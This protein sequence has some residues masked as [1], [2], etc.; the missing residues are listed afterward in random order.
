MKTK[1]KWYSIEN[2]SNDVTDIYI[3]DTIGQDYW[4]DGISGETFI[5]DLVKVTTD[6]INFWVNCPGGNVFEAN[7][8]FNAIK[9]HPAKNKIM[10]I[11][12]MAASAASYI[13]MACDERIIYDGGVIM[14]HLPS[15][16]SYG[17]KN[18]LHK[19]I[20]VLETIQ[21]EMVQVYK[22]QLSLSE[23]E[24]DNLLEA[25]TWIGSN[26]A[27]EMGFCTKKDET[28]AVAQINNE[29]I[30]ELH[31]KN[32][33]KNLIKREDPTEDKVKELLKTQGYSNEQING[34][35]N[36]SESKNEELSKDELEKIKNKLNGIQI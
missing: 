5:K 33:P 1:N 28:K 22:T 19:T 26:K 35:F 18:E 20:D 2:K 17:N 12:G 23:E 7:S 30:Q 24:I 6:T 27:V 9:R 14:V 21:N 10:H 3:M 29:L 34:F 32:V 16:I 15:C 11:T 13:I 31:Y 8:I 25:E 36:K 4:G